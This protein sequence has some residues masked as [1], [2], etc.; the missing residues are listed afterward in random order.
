MV[1]GNLQSLFWLCW[2]FEATVFLVLRAGWF[3]TSGENHGIG[4]HFVEME[5]NLIEFDD[6]MDQPS[7]SMD[8]EN[9]DA[10]DGGESTGE[11][12]IESKAPVSQLVNADD[13]SVIEIKTQHYLESTRNY[14]FAQFLMKNNHSCTKMIVNLF[15]AH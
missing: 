12:N 5:R 3:I 10:V 1:Y 9:C 7:H 4:E 15:P 6:H 13:T 11:L 14:I 8:V 2:M